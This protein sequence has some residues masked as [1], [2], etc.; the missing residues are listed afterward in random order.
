MARLNRAAAA[1]MTAVGAHAATDVTGFGLLGHAWEMAQASRADLVINSRSVAF[2]P[3]AIELAGLGLFPG[4]SERNR[5]FMT[6]RAD[7]ATGVSEEMRMLLCDAQTSGGLLIAVHADR[8]AELLDRLRTA[9]VVDA[10]AIGEVV[11][12]SG[13]IRV[14]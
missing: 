2:L 12:G 8:V 11:A 5:E 4:G 7:F 10:T 3:G 14:R 1:A 9:G 13:R 6:S